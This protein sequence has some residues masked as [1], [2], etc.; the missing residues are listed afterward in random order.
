[1]L[2]VGLHSVPDDTVALGR[3]VEEALLQVEVSVLDEEVGLR[4]VE[5]I[6]EYLVDEKRSVLVIDV[7][8]DVVDSASIMR[9]RSETVHLNGGSASSS[10]LST[11]ATDSAILKK[12]IS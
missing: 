7:V 2:S 11:M 6:L 5:S 10:G 3:V 8:V 4:V 9:S 1:M 12:V